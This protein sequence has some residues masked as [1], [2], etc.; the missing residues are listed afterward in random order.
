MAATNHWCRR[1]S[2]WERPTPGSTGTYG[3]SLGWW[4]GGRGERTR[5]G[6]TVWATSACRVAGATGDTLSGRKRAGSH[7]Q[8][9][10]HHKHVV[11]PLPGLV[12]GC[13]VGAGDDLVRALVP[14]TYG[15]LWAEGAAPVCAQGVPNALVG[16]MYNPVESMSGSHGKRHGSVHA[17]RKIQGRGGVHPP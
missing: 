7:V 12:A 15:G 2:H 11:V 4:W 3:G 16:C 8:P 6:E 14:R 5:V 13:E 10:P 17:R 1:A 9:L